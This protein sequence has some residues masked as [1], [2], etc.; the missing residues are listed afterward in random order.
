MDGE[1][2]TH[3]DSWFNAE[4]YEREQKQY[5]VDR[6]RLRRKFDIHLIGA[7]PL[8]EKGFIEGLKYADEWHKKRNRRGK[9]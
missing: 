8:Y 2:M 9:K 3:Y 4:K 7:N 5:I 1:K 6:N